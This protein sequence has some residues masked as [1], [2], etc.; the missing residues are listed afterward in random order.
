MASAGSQPGEVH[1]FAL[2]TLAAREIDASGLRSKHWSELP[3]LEFDRVI[4]LCDI[5]R[6]E[7]PRDLRGG[8]HWSI[9]DPV[10]APA[11]SRR[12]AFAAA[13]DQIQQR[14]RALMAEMSVAA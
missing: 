1:P 14:V 12:R 10:A 5:V 6:E 3:S 2:E 9:E 4:T 7:L 13:A 11:S 8:A